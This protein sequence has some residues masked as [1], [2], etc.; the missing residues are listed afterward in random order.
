MNEILEQFKIVLGLD[1]KPLQDGLKKSESSLKSF[2]KVFGGL[3]ASYFSYEIF[4][5]VILGFADFNT[6]LSQ[7]IDLTGGSIESI[8]AMGN[9]LKRFGGDTQSVISSM[10]SLNSSLQEAKFGG[11]ALI[12]LS[13]RYGLAFSP[14]ASAEDTIKSLASQMGNYS[15]ETRVAIGRTL[16][17]DDSLIRAFADGGDELERL[18]KKQ[19]ELG[20]ITDEDVKISKQFNNA[21]LDLQDMFSALMRDISRVVLPIFTKLFGFLYD[22][23]ELIRSHKQLVLGFFIAIGVALIPIVA[24]FVK[25]A[26]ASV[27]AF[28]PVY[29]VIGALATVLIVLEDIYYYFKG[30]DSVTGQLVEKF[31]ALASVL[32]FI[33]PLVM[34]IFDTFDGIVN[35]LKDPSWSNFAD[36]FKIAGKAL[37]DFSANIRKVFH[38]LLDEMGGLFES[39]AKKINPMNWFGDDESKLAVSHVPTIPPVPNVPVPNAVRNNNISSNYNINNNFNQN[40]TGANSQQVANDTNKMIINSINSQSQQ[41]GSF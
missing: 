18:I 41:F 39:L 34:G 31:P 13:K 28:A 14:F 21:W 20:V 26:V 15:R 16:G 3:I 33:K 32:E 22:F 25:M 24:A 40:I 4:R 6:K 17:L 7:S 1:D 37:I 29:A 38:A 35:F 8:S 23:V 11:G 5:G 19:K 9:A 2:G 12:E 27:V 36:I 30:W 10:E